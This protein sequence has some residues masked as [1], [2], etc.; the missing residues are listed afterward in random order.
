MQYMMG[1]CR[2]FLI[3]LLLSALPEDLD[4]LVL[5]LHILWS[6]TARCWSWDTLGK[7]ATIH[8]VTTM[9]ATSK[10]VLVPGPNHLLTTSADDFG[11]FRA[12]ECFYPRFVWQGITNIWEYWQL[13]QWSSCEIIWPSECNHTTV[14]FKLSDDEIDDM[15]ISI[16][17]ALKEL[18]AKGH[19][20][21]P[22]VE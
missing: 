5:S 8:Q 14:T 3:E 16:E 6:S 13:W 12:D 19:P 21:W 18:F 20:A 11:M 15:K 7:K 10:N 22:L 4:D 2:L 1:S 9:L 17:K